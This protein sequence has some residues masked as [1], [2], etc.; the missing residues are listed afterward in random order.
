MNRQE[1]YFA[2]VSLVVIS[3]VLAAASVGMTQFNDV[4]GQNAT[5]T[6]NQTGTAVANQTTASPMQNQTATE[7]GNLTSAW[8]ETVVSDLSAARNALHSQNMLEAYFALGHADGTLFSIAADPNS[9]AQM[10][11]L[12]E[13]FKPLNDHLTAAQFALRNNDTSM[14]LEEINIAD[15]E[16]LKLNQQLPP[17]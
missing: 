13:K 8:F 14:A 2:K 15:T 1:S 5:T 9:G 3:S 6:A 16:F 10:T 12:L 11:I 17:G 4:L 7:F